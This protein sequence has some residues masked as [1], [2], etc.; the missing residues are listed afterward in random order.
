MPERTLRLGGVYLLPDGRECVVGIRSPEGRTFLYLTEVWKK[1]LPTI[2]MPIAYEV[3]RDGSVFTGAGRLTGWH[4]GSLADTG[5][6]L[7]VPCR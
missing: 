5:S 6:C 2:S 4:V 7:D 1:G 3:G